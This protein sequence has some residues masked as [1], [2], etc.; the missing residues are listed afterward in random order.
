MNFTVPFAW[1]APQP[2]PS[3]QVPDIDPNDRDLV[4]ILR[5]AAALSDKEKSLVLVLM[6]TISAWGGLSGGAAQ[7]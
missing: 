4:A 5:A 2:D 1:G 7:R 3:G 6:Q